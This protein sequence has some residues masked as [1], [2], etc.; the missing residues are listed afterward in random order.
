VTRSGASMDV[1]LFSSVGVSSVMFS[2]P[3]WGSSDD[4]LV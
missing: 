4:T 1:G 2:S 3:N